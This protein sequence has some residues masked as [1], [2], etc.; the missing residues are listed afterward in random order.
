MITTNIKL[1]NYLLH[2]CGY[3]TKKLSLPI[4]LYNSLDLNHD[5]TLLNDTK[6][7]NQI[8]ALVGF[9]DL[10][11]FSTFSKDK[12]PI[13]IRDYIKPFLQDLVGI[14]SS[15]ALIDKTIGD[16]IMFILPFPNEYGI[17]SG[18]RSLSDLF[19]EISNYTIEHNY[20]F[21]IGMSFGSVLIDYIKNENYSEFAAFGE[22]I[23][24]AKRIMDDEMLKNPN[25][26]IC[27]I[28]NHKNNEP[29][30][31][32]EEIAKACCSRINK[33][34][35]INSNY[36]SDKKGIGKIE[37]TIIEIKSET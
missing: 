16:E 12:T 22:V 11:G 15:H 3:D 37:A 34:K 1:H 33:W 7:S 4:I 17:V 30:F 19:D 25:P 18:W 5:K 23:I 35:I 29:K 9:I 32:K 2:R 13:E 36:P 6:G 31:D 10:K 14:V 8:N 26:C 28:V 20:N 21:R 24:Y 27:A